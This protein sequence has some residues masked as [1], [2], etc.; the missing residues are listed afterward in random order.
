[1]ATMFHTG[2]QLSGY[3]FEDSH[4]TFKLAVGLDATYIGKPVALDTANGTVKVCGD[5]DRVHGI[6]ASFEDRIVEGSR[7]GAVALRFA[8]KLETTGA[9][10]VGDS[11]V[12][13]ATAGKV[14]AATEADRNDNIVVEVGTGY[15]I[16]HRV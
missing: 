10:A 14:K 13:S 11:V 16:V 6:L 9:V 12:G 7:V 15:A 3:H 5:G 4:I 8:T 1:M 2:V